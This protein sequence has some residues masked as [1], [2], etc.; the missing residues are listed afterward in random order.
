[1]KY[2]MLPLFALPSFALA[3]GSGS[4]ASLSLLQLDDPI[5]A[6]LQVGAEL[7]ES[8]EMGVDVVLEEEVDTLVW[9]VTFDQSLLEVEY[10]D[11]FFFVR[12]EQ[13]ITEP[14]SSSAAS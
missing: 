11:Q 5:E 8:P 13:A 9:A 2:L 3:Q 4:N 10:E 14:C 7:A 1:M 12:A 6:C